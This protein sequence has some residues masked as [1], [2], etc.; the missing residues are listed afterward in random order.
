M[1]EVGVSDLVVKDRYDVRHFFDI[2]HSVNGP[3]V[4]LAT[5]RRPIAADFDWEGEL[6][7][8]GH[9]VVVVLRNRY[10]A[11][12]RSPYRRLTVVVSVVCFC[13]A[14]GCAD[15]VRVVVS[16]G[17]GV[18]C[19]V[20]Y[21]LFNRDFFA[22]EGSVLYVVLTNFVAFYV[23]LSRVG[24]D[25]DASAWNFSLCLIGRFLTDCFGFLRAHRGFVNVRGPLVVGLPR[26]VVVAVHFVRVTL[27]SWVNH[28]R[29]YVYLPV[30]V[31]D[32]YVA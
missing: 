1:V 31:V 19:K 20:A 25:P 15:L 17:V 6:P 11:Y 18:F 13:S 28:L 32:L 16:F 27:P 8:V 23:G 5:D 14:R 21:L 2:H 24:V 7:Y 22:V 26:L 12:L 9:H 3:A 30:R 4:R 29:P 10:C